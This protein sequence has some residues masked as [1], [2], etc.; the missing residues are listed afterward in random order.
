MKQNFFPT[1]NAALL[2]E[3]LI[4]YWPLGSNIQYGETV[5]HIVDTP[6]GSKLISVYRNEVGNYERPIHYHTN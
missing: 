4:D 6:T 3:N 1:L 5:Q 2:S